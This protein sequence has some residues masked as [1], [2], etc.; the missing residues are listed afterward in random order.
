MERPSIE[1][2]FPNIESGLPFLQ[3]YAPELCGRA[4]KEK[5][6]R[7]VAKRFLAKQETQELLPTRKN[8]GREEER[9][10][11]R[12]TGGGG[13]QRSPTQ[14]ARRMRGA[15]PSKANRI[16]RRPHVFVC[17]PFSFSIF[18]YFFISMWAL[19]RFLIFHLLP[20][21]ESC[22]DFAPLYSMPDFPI[23]S[24]LLAYFFLLL[25]PKLGGRLGTRETSR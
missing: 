1:T 22:Q 5:P 3:L 19:A 20:C 11:E 15:P 10:R 16:P 23:S 13:G 25:F 24:L 8:G 2:P 4:K 12:G 21:G 6:E 17:L 18:P 9:K 7:S 14:V